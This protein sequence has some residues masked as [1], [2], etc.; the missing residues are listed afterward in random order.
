MVMPPDPDGEPANPWHETVNAPTPHRIQKPFIEI[1]WC[2]GYVGYVNMLR[3]H[4]ES[5]AEVARTV[6]WTSWIDAR[7]VDIVLDEDKITSLIGIAL[8]R[9]E[10][11][12]AQRG[13]GTLSA[14]NH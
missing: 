11:S 10:V 13:A 6:P 5:E 4:V 7:N 3:Y 1:D 14:Y 2:W 9:A 12:A 8:H